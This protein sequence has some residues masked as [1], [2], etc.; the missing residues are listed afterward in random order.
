MHHHLAATSQ[1]VLWGNIDPAAQPVLTVFPR[2][3]CH[4]RGAVRRVAEPSR[5]EYRLSS[6]CRTS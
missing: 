6:T 5:P 4:D 3:Q 2:R 1:T